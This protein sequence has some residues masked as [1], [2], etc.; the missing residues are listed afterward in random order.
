MTWLR[1]KPKRF[2]VEITCPHGTFI[3]ATFRIDGKAHRLG[4]SGCGIKVT[5]T[6]PA[7]P[8]P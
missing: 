8:A 1:R 4:C 7:R 3:P 2:R 5:V 6:A